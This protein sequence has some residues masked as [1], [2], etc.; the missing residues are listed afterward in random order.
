MIQTVAY[1]KRDA[2]RE[3]FRVG[4]HESHRGSAR[5]G[6]LQGCTPNKWTKLNLSVTWQPGKNITIPTSSHLFSPWRNQTPPW[7]TLGLDRRTGLGPPAVGRGLL[8][9]ALEELPVHQVAVDV[10]PGQRHGAQLLEVKVQ[11]V[12]STIKLVLWCKRTP[13]DD[14]PMGQ[15]RKATGLQVIPTS[16]TQKRRTQKPQPFGMLFFLGL[17]SSSQGNSITHRMRQQYHGHPPI[18]SPKGRR[19]GRVA[20]RSSSSWSSPSLFSTSIVA[21]N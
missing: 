1:A 8:A 21:K 10:V 13:S 3:H 7:L 6:P 17:P 5:F 15:A 19:T 11:D 16:R 18:P 9:T 14:G 4:R 20:T 12:P 2:H